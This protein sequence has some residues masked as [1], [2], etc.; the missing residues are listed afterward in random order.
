MIWVEER[1]FREGRHALL[2]AT[3]IEGCEA[4]VADGEFF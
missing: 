2:M 3:E 1:E 4:T